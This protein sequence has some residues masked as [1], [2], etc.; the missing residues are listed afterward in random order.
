MELYVLAAGQM[1]NLNRWQ[2]DLNSM[3][4]PLYRNG[5]KIPK[6]RRRLLV[7]PVQLFK[8]GFA[9]EELNNVVAAVCPVDDYVSRKYDVGFVG[10]MIRNKLGLKPSPTPKLINPYLQPNAYDKAV[11]IMPLGIKEDIMN[12]EGV[13]QL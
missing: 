10:K 3:W 7:A 11:A 4:L 1:D 5:E 8:I 12:D 13:E 6:Q 9:K 2:Q